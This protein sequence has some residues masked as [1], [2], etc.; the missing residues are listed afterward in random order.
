MRAAVIGKVKTAAV[1]RD[2]DLTSGVRLPRTDENM[3]YTGIRISAV[4]YGI[5]HN[6]LQRQRRHTEMG[7][8]RVVIDRQTFL[9]LGLLQRSMPGTTVINHNPSILNRSAAPSMEKNWNSPLIWVYEIKYNIH[10]SR[11]MQRRAENESR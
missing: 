5:L 11:I 2:S 3:Q 10:Y 4:L 7:M 6:R 8:G 9:V 1:I